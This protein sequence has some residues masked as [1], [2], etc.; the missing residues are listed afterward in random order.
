MCYYVAALFVP[1]ASQFTT[2]AYHH[3]D[4]LMES[5]IDNK[6]LMKI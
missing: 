5:V 1:E 6:E 2:G 3:A 4:M